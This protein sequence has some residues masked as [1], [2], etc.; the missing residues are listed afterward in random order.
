MEIINEYN[1][2][3]G[4]KINIQNSGAFLCTNNQQSEKKFRRD[5]LSI[6]WHL[7]KA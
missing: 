7:F 4:Y 6:L 1:K 2:V 3:S 5:R